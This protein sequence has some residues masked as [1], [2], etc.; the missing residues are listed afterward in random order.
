MTV[1][2]KPELETQVV[3]K[4]LAE[5][6]TVDQYIEQLIR[7]EEA[8]GELNEE[9]LNESH[10]EFA[11]IQAA[12]SEGLEQAERGESR[13]AEEVFRDLRVKYSVPG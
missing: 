13:P 2:I 5:G 6:L 8:W 10:P 3:E 7:G 11:A 12:V 4:A 1:M 9:A